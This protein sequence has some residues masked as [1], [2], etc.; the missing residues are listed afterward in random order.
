[1][2]EVLSHGIIYVIV[3][4]KDWE[5][6]SD[7]VIDDKPVLCKWMDYNGYHFVAGDEAVIAKFHF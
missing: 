6:F 4:R 7:I 5:W 1:M 3:D 2:G